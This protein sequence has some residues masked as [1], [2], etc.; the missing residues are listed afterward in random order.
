MKKERTF[1]EAI[2][3]RFGNKY[4]TMQTPLAPEMFM[5]GRTNQRKNLLKTGNFWKQVAALAA[6][7]EKSVQEARRVLEEHYQSQQ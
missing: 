5:Q 3:S 7:F 4:A 6:L 2:I 1:E